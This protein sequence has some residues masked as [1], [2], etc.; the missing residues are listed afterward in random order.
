MSCSAGPNIVVDGL[1][2]AYDMGPNP[3]V[4]KSWKGK[5]TTNLVTDTPSMNGWAGTYTVVDSSTKTFLIQTT[6]TNAATTSAWRTWYWSVSSYVGQY[7]TISGDVE[8]VSETNATFQHITIGQGNTGSFPYHIAGSDPADRV[9]IN[10]KPFNKIHM[11]WSG[12]IN[13]TGVVGFTQ[14]ISNVTANGGNGVLKISNVQIEANSFETP[15]VNG[16]RSNTQTLLDWAG[17]NST[18]V[19][20]LTYASDGSFTFDGSNDGITLPALHFPTEQT[21]E[22]WLKPLENDG[23]RRNPYN[24]AYGGYGTWTH[25]TSGAINYYYGDGGG[26]ASPYIGHGSSFTVAQNELAC[27]ATTRN[28]SQSIWYK[29][30]VAYN[31][32]THSFGELTSHTS[33]ITIGTGYAGRYLGD[34]YAVRLYN[35]ALSADEI[36]QNFN[37]MRRR[38]G[39]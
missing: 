20:D 4:N 17:R 7:V 19:N 32:Y 10:E 37:A 21:I 16:T 12:I 33:S 3:G 13:A 25:E 28:T 39:I 27:V 24:Q 8:F 23:F 9:T 38:Y 22:I 6:Q 18:T 14:W 26:N 15:F 30:G 36:A 31:S 5:P 29:N 35:R 1:V 11:T 34:I 2:F